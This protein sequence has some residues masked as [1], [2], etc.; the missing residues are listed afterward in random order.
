MS[1]SYM[2]LPP[3]LRN[4]KKRS[5]GFSLKKRFVN[6]LIGEGEPIEENSTS[7]REERFRSDGIQLQIYKASG[8]YVVE[9]RSYDRVKDRNNTS[10]H[11]ITEDEDLGN[12]I[13]KIIVMESLR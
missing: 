10:M 8:G 11:V 12:R 1:T 2:P 4:R 7:L 5:I 9:T 6:W 13:G 3:S